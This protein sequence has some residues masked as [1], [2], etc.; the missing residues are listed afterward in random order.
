M[1]LSKG[2]VRLQDFLF[3][4]NG[5]SFSLAV[6]AVIPHGVGSAFC[7][8]NDVGLNRAGN[9]SLKA[10]EGVHPRKRAHN[11]NYGSGNVSGGTID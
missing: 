3:K 1:G 9:M 6:V 7:N 11:S 4:W 8:P 2:S 10:R 5:G